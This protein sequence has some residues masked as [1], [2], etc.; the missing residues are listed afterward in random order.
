MA[1]PEAVTGDSTLKNLS[2]CESLAMTEEREPRTVSSEPPSRLG[3]RQGRA[4][5]TWGNCS[6]PPSV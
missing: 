5:E 1:L 4:Y 6:F 2:G 3:R